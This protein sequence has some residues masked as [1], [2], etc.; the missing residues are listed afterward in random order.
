MP[1]FPA[2]IGACVDALY[3][4]R[5]RRLALKKEMDEVGSFESALR[6]H[7]LKKFGKAKLK[8]AKG[9]IASASLAENTV[10]DVKDWD[11][12]F[13]WVVKHR[14]WDM[15]TH[16]LNDRAYRERLDAKIPMDPKMIEP[17][18][19]TSLHVNKL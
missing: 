10:A 17:F 19:V 16:K 5:Q 6:E 15:L 9:N 14:A 11:L 1:K 13:A 3:K 8:G 7:V 12:M 2:T 18:I 4:T